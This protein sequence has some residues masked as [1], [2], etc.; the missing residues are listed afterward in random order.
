MKGLL[1]KGHTGCLRSYRQ[2]LQTLLTHEHGVVVG[3]SKLRATG[4]V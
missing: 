1:I 3:S 4:R 2:Q